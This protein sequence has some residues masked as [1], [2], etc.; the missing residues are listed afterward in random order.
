VEGTVLNGLNFVVSV[1][2][3][4]SALAR[5]IVAGQEFELARLVLDHSWIKSAYR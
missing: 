1:S 2:V 3:G 4:D 5:D